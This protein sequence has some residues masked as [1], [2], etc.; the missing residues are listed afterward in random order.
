MNG[1]LADYGTGLLLLGS[2]I[3]LGAALFD[4]FWTGN[5]I[6][7]TDGAL[8][9]IVTTALMV[10]ATVA[11][12][13]WP[14]TPRW[15]RAILLVLILLDICGTGFAAYM[16]EAWWEVGAMALALVGWIVRVAGGSIGNRPAPAQA[17]A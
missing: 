15:I 17:R 9:V 7:G 14:E 1:R 8:L 2:L 13:I 6:H 11:L 12:L 16:L 3:G 4:F 5:G 10:L